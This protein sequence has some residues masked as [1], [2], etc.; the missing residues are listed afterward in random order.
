MAEE[1]EK[2]IRD[3]FSKAFENALGEDEMDSEEEE[4]LTEEDEE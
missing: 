2:K 4:E 3:N 1:L